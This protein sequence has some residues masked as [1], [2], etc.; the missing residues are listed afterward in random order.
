MFEYFEPRMC[1]GLSTRWILFYQQSN[2]KRT[3]ANENK[4][5]CFLLFFHF[6]KGKYGYDAME[7]VD[8]EKIYFSKE[9]AWDTVYSFSLSITA[10]ARPYLDR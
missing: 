8:R 10:R 1:K 3:K 9:I 4:D 6:F 2:D 5:F 7:N